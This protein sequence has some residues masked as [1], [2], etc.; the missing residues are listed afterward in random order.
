MIA[1]RLSTI[2]YAHRIVVIVNGQIVEMGTH[3]ELMA[4]QGEYFKLYQ[5][6][7]AATS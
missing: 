1:H 5:M 4:R 6:Q 3:E 2:A 7:F